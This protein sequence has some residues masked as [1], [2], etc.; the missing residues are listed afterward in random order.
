MNGSTPYCLD[1]VFAHFN[2]SWRWNYDDTILILV[3]RWFIS[4]D[5]FTGTYEEVAAHEAKFGLK[6][7]EDKSAKEQE[8]EKEKDKEETLYHIYEAVVDNTFLLF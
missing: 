3:Y 7:G 8:E 5:G 1:T 2:F 6:S 4:Q